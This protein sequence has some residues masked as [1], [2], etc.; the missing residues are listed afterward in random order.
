MNKNTDD[1]E[2]GIIK[3]LC[4]TSKQLADA[5]LNSDRART[6][7]IFKAITELASSVNLKVRVTEENKANNAWLYDL[8]VFDGTPDDIYKVWV[9]LESEWNPYLDHIKYDFYKLVQSR[10]ML[11]VML[12]KSDDCHTIT[13]TLVKIVETSEMSESGDRY[14]FAGWDWEKRH[15]T[16]NGMFHIRQ[17]TKA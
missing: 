13:N 16:D 10:S 7:A 12:F 1:I 14:L 5:E 3:V 8:T 4:D 6:E 11:R 2:Q 17:Y 15:N 9:A